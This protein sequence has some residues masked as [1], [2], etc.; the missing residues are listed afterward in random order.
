VSDVAERLSA[1]RERVARA[2][3][4]AGRPEGS[5]RLLAV[6]KTFAPERVIEAAGCGLRAFGENRVQEAEQKIPAVRAACS[7]DLEWHL[8]GA[9]QRNKARRAAELFDVIHSLDRPSLARSL[10]RAAESLDKRL[11]V[12]VQVNVDAEPQKGGVRPDDAASLL[13]QLA[14]LPRLDPVGLMA[15]PRA[16]PEPELVRPAFARLRSLLE[17]LRIDHPTLRELSMGMTADFEVAI[18]EGATWIRLGTAL[19][20]ERSP[21]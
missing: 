12:L 16:Q 5:V 21:A 11:R 4:A 15:I 6:S 19:F 17:E 14:A 7:A 3:R 10:D 13:D 8:V 2:E 9:L 20:G 18:S 1:I